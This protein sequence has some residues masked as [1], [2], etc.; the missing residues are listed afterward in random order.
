MHSKKIIK[1]TFVALHTSSEVMRLF[2]MFVPA[3]CVLY[4]YKIEMTKVEFFFVYF[5]T[6]AAPDTKPFTHLEQVT[7]LYGYDNICS[8]SKEY[9]FLFR[10]PCTL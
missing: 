9:T 6:D 5:H 4:L 2:L 1:L 7:K 3:V 8:R 10:L